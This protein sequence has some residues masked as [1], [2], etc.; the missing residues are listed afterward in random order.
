M[1]KNS[2]RPILQSI[3]VLSLFLCGFSFDS[4]KPTIKQTDY[5]GSEKCISCHT[6]L[7]SEIIKEW[8]SSRHHLSM[9]EFPDYGNIIPDSL[10][11]GENIIAV[12]GNS[13]DILIDSD[14]RLI[15]KKDLRE[16][17]FSPPHNL[18]GAADIIIDASQSCFGCHSTGYFIREKKYIEPGIGCEACHGPGSSHIES[19][20][21]PNSIV[22]PLKISP[23]KNRMICGQCHSEGLD[24]SGK[25]PFPVIDGQFPFQPGND[26]KDIF[27]DSK[28]M[29]KTNGAEYSTFIG[30]PEPY[31]AQ[32]C[33]DCHSPHGKNENPNMLI[34]NS[35]KLCKKC[36]GN[37]LGDIAYV[38]EKVHWGA[39]RY[40]CWNCHEYA[41]IH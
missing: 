34:Y 18:I 21:S 32:L 10:I 23:D 6:E 17:N 40:K 12:I 8:K 9:K 22:N 30:S 16:S 31:S 35:S 4:M 13:M 20:G 24:A 36:H 28:P 26:L 39:Y 15:I 19:G 14:F 3:A 38:N 33:T 37:P 1:S 2:N 25:H 29:K 27:V 41:H 5:V 7:H 11:Y